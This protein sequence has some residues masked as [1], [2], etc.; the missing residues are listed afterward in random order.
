MTYYYY[1]GYHFYIRPLHPTH[2]FCTS[3]LFPYLQFLPP[4]H[5]PHPYLTTPP[6][7]LLQFHVHPY[8]S[9]PAVLL[10][11]FHPYRSTP[12]VLLL[13][14]HPYRSTPTVPPLPFHPYR[15]TPPVPPLPFHPYRSTLQFHP[16][17]HSRSAASPCWPELLTD[18]FYYSGPT[19]HLTLELSWFLGTRVL[20]HPNTLILY[21]RE[22]SGE[23]CVPLDSNYTRVAKTHSHL[24]SPSFQFIPWRW[25]LTR[26][27]W[28]V[29]KLPEGWARFVSLFGHKRWGQSVGWLDIQW[30]FQFYDISY[31]NSAQN[32]SQYHIIAFIWY[33]DVRM[34]EWVS[35]L[36]GLNL[37][38]Y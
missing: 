22:V 21:D 31:R 38:F 16:F 14:F 2:A 17:L 29:Y 20:P 28:I 35:M 1:V 5:S 10:F 19:S 18:Q 13:Q 3:V 9:T 26:S 36:P 32:I 30:H 15:S 6:F 11:Q 27:L 24:P 34:L 4:T 33:I 25:E 37:E 7:L 23:H 8:R 12:A